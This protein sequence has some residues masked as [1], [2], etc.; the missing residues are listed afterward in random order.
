MSISKSKVRLILEKTPSMTYTRPSISTTPLYLLFH[1]WGSDQLHMMYYGSISI[2]NKLYL[3][4]PRQLKPKMFK[5]QLKMQTKEG[6]QDSCLENIYYV[7]SKQKLVKDTSLPSS[8]PYSRKN[9][10]HTHTHTHT[11][12]TYIK[13]TFA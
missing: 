3:S 8:H 13:Y 5:G 1:I 9:N 12:Y 2:E 4:R 11:I 7:I 6:F 10:T